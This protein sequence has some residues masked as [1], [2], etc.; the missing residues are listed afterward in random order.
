MKGEWKLA[1]RGVEGEATPYV[2]PLGNL[3]LFRFWLLTRGWLAGVL[4]APPFRHSTP[5]KGE[6]CCPPEGVNAQ[7]GGYSLSKI[8]EAVPSL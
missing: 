2:V 5:P 8:E 4:M 3:E 6:G 7:G 1:D